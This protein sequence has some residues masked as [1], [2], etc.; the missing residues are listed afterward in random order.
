M[1][2]EEIPDHSLLHQR[3][4]VKLRRMLERSE[5]HTIYRSKKNI[6]DFLRTV[7]DVRDPLSTA[8][9]YFPNTM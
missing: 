5:I 8:G 4:S 3:I 7:K 6:M 2:S 1:A 9:V